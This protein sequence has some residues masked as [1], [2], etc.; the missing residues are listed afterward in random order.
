MVITEL[1]SKKKFL[2]FFTSI[3]QS[4]SFIQFSRRT[5]LIIRFK[6]RYEIWSVWDR[7]KISIEF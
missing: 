4:I 5:K 3:E 2:A 1:G 7:A 6:W